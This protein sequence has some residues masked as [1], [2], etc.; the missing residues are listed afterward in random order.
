[1]IKKRFPIFYGKKHMSWSTGTAVW[2]AG[3]FVFLSGTEGRSPD[4]DEVVEGM[5]AQTKMCLTKIKERLEEFGTSLDNICHLWY[6][7]KGPDFPDG[8][9]NDPKWIEA[10]KARYE[11]W[12]ENG[13]PDFVEDKNPPP[14]TLL[15]VSS[16][17]KKEMLIEITAIAALPPLD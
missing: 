10:S 5:A 14:G 6:Y 4:T 12:L 15:G 13:Y 9:Q 1:M 16:L 11:F 17:A 7:I 3:G 2:G 8:I